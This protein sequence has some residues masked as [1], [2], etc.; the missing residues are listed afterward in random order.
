[1]QN[2]QFEKATESGTAQW[3]FGRHCFFA[4]RAV[5]LLRMAKYYATSGAQRVS[6]I[7]NARFNASEARRQWQRYCAK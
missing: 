4:G 7:E 2:A 1:M 5:Q 3:F 6:F